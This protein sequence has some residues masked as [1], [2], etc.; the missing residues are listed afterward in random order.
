MV[1]KKKVRLYLFIFKILFI[2]Q[3]QKYF[4]LGCSG[5]TVLWWFQA[6]S[7]ETQPYIH[8]WPFL[9]FEWLQGW[10]R[11]S[12]RKHKQTT[13]FSFI[14]L[15]LFF[16]NRISWSHHE[17]LCKYA[18]F[19]FTGEN[20]FLSGSFK[21]EKKTRTPPPQTARNRKVE[22]VIWNWIRRIF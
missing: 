1:Q 6:N 16:Y 7:E 5:L 18:S 17:E 3:H 12:L 21:E 13:F 11:R 15:Q 9:Y 4:V 2:F 20:H 14:F 10:G 22:I 8:M 19:D